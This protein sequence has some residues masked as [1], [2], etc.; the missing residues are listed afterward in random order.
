MSQETE[1]SL[2]R[3][4]KRQGEKIAALQS[5]VAALREVEKE[6]D[7]YLDCLRHTHEAKY[8]TVGDKDILTEECDGCG[9]NL[10]HPV[11][12]AKLDEGRKP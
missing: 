6:R 10:R 1:D 11:H 9:R 4:C 3:L 2:A 5:E 7:E 12:F 8:I